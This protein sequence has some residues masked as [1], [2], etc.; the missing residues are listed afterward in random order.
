MSAEKE[1]TALESS[2]GADAVQSSQK[3]SING[4][5]DFSGEFNGDEE[6]S[7]SISAVMDNLKRY[8]RYTLS[9]N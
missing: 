2:V 9:S 8:I 3:I 7:T 5:S 4:I 1:M 6:I